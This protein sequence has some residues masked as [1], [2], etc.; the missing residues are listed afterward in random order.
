MAFDLS[1]APAPNVSEHMTSWATGSFKS[2]D[3]IREVRRSIQLACDMS[4]MLS[5]DKDFEKLTPQ[6]K[7]NKIV[8]RMPELMFKGVWLIRALMEGTEKNPLFRA[9]MEMF[10]R[11]TD[12][13]TSQPPTLEQANMT[14][15][16][17]MAEVTR[18]FYGGSTPFA[19]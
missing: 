11:V 2:F 8:Q 7:V 9:M 6:E 12:F 14:I 3:E 4:R 10:L 1:N 5:A 15:R 18:Y 13:S 19:L 16:D 17:A